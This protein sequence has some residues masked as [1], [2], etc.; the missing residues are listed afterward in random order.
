MAIG[1]IRLGK[2][3]VTFQLWTKQTTVILREAIRGDRWVQIWALTI[4]KWNQKSF[5]EISRCYG[6]FK[7]VDDCSNRK[8]IVS[9][10]RMKFG[11]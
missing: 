7:E 10:V 6:G 8:E 9:A 2:G 3:V 4:S 11:A 5:R 1:L